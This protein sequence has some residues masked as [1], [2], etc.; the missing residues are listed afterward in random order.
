M[1][2]FVWGDCCDVPQG[3]VRTLHYHTSKVPQ[4]Y[5]NQTIEAV[6]ARKY[7]ETLVAMGFACNLADY[8]QFPYYMRPDWDEKLV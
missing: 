4:N 8:S 5:M 1:I 6:A 2:R 3:Q 7:W